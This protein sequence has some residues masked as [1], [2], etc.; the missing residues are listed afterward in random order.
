M[1]Q[2]PAD[3]IA[4]RARPEALGVDDPG[5]LLRQHLVPHPLST[6]LLRAGSDHLAAAGIRRGDL[7]L[8]DRG[9]TPRA[10]DVVVA[11]AADRLEVRR[12]G[13]DAG[14]PVA[15][16]GVVTAVVHQ[17]RGRAPSAAPP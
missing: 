8:V 3:P 13:G 12:L 15:V 4:F 6:F 11:S 2:L 17:L 16:W 14:E 5:E 1:E 10:C 9:L 7:L